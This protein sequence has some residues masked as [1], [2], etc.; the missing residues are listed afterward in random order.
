MSDKQR[1]FISSAQ[2]EFAEE[3]AALRDYLRGDPLLVEPLY[4]A[5]YIERMGTGTRDMIRRCREAGLP[6][7]VFSISDGFMTTIRR[8]IEEVTGEVMR[9]LLALKGEMK[10]K[11]IQDMLEL[12]HEEHFL[13]PICFPL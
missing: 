4:L 2:K 5:R 8:K 1:I 11:E 13:Q 12:R 10:R 3:R 9:L 7:P 6:E